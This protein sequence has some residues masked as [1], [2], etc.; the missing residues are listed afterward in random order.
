M[1]LINGT[2]GGLGR[3]LETL[4]RWFSIDFC[5]FLLLLHLYLLF[6]ANLTKLNV[7]HTRATNRAP[8]IP[9]QTQS[10]R[11]DWKSLNK[12]SFLIL[13]KLL[14]SLSQFKFQYILITKSLCTLFVWDHQLI[15]KRNT[16]FFCCCSCCIDGNIIV[17]LWTLLDYY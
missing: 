12:I 13:Q 17:A 16:L 2:S 14:I 6:F 5:V 15:F 8:C 4:Y 7:L 9:R 10:I 3:S 11:T 1:D